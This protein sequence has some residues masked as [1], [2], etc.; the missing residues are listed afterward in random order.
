VVIA[1][2]HIYGRW[3]KELVQPSSIS[4]IATWSVETL[5]HRNAEMRNCES[6]WSPPVVISLKS[7]REELKETSSIS[8]FGTWR[9][10]L[11]LHRIPEMRNACS[12]LA[13]G[14]NLWSHRRSLKGGASTKL[15]SISEI[16]TW[17]VETLHHRNAE[18]PNCEMAKST[19]DPVLVIQR[20]WMLGNLIEG[21]LLLFIVNRS[22]MI[23]LAELNH[24]SW[25][26]GDSVADAF[27]WRFTV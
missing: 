18:M 13:P 22:V 6:A 27:S 11:T 10:F 5:Y 17:G 2:G 9:V 1:T 8:E 20:C 19:R 12:K 23:Q 4:V 26:V 3:R 24:D 15:I 25:T 16:A 7:C 14:H 21:L